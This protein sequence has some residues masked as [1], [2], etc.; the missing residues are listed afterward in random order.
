[1]RRKTKLR[2]ALIGS[3]TSL[4]LCCA[5]LVGTTYA[6]LNESVT[7]ASNRIAAGTFAVKLLKYEEDDDGNRTYTDISGKTGDLF[8][9]DEPFTWEPGTEKTVKL[10]I[11]NDGNL[12][13]KY[14]LG[15]VVRDAGLAELLEYSIVSVEE[16]D[17][18]LVRMNLDREYDE[19]EESGPDD[20]GLDYIDLI[21]AIENDNV[22][23]ETEIESGVSYVLISGQR[24]L[25]SSEQNGEAD[26]VVM[27]HD[28][29]DEKTEAELEREFSTDH[30]ELTVRMKDI[31]TKALAS[32]AKHAQCEI[33]ICVLATQAVEENGEEGGDPIET[34]I[35]KV[36][37]Y[38]YHFTTVAVETD[39]E[40][41][42]YK[43]ADP[44][45]A[46]SSNATIGIE[47]AEGTWIEGDIAKE[48]DTKTVILSVKP[49]N[50]ELDV[51][52]ETKTYTQTIHVQFYGVAEEN[53]IPF[54]L[55]RYLGTGIHLIELR[56]NN[57]LE[58]DSE[59]EP[60][61]IYKEEE[62]EKNDETSEGEE[63]AEPIEMEYNEEIGFG[64]SYAPEIGEVK[65]QSIC[66]G[67]LTIVWNI[68]AETE[69]E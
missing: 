52:E 25:T 6:W 23:E 7:S 22:D 55:T 30:Y 41:E 49:E 31:A 1:M 8:Q 62:L 67:D 65:I 19:D 33:D 27:A 3:I 37:D 12:P 38:I 5:M 61:L 34:P 26:A 10:A 59:S 40:T 57:P 56:Y 46:S 47:L 14:E 44:V 18:E 24:I 21:D 69:E 9:G 20:S 16:R 51:L 36:E 66:Q 48:E 17:E 68:P 45:S 64:F 32:R 35:P 28:D 58:E 4:T 43:T 53:D 39:E 29:S 50:P 54:T 13:M 11:R 60:I 42:T 63:N 15:L 2:N